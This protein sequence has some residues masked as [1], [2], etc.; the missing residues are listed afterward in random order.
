MGDTFGDGESDEKPVHEVC[1][2]DF[3]IGKY[4][5]TQG[6]WVEIMGSNSSSFD[7]CGENCPM[8]SVS[9]D[10]LQDFL[11]KLKK[12]TGK[13]YRLPTEAEWEYAARSGGKREKWSGTSSE[14]DLGNYAWYV[15]NSKNQTHPV[16]QKKPN[17]LGLYDMSGNV[18]EWVADWYD[19]GYYEKSPVE[20]P[21]GPGDGAGRVL[22]GG[23]SLFIE[24]AGVVRAAIRNSH[25]PYYSSAFSGFRL[26][27]D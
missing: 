14:S 15:K 18:W 2:K 12:R 7:K 3:R 20:A 24:D 1:V 16:G 6:Q 25:P 10:D 22:R 5:L 19:E 17:G 9:W 8:D 13:N 21:N 27:T 23:S 4:E 26:A 11:K